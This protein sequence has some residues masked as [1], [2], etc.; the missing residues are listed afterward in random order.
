MATVALKTLA[1]QQADICRVFSNPTRI[2]IVWTLLEREMS[3]SAIAEAVD[4]SLQSTS[5]H[6]RIMKQKQVLTSRRDAQTVY[7][8]ISDMAKVSCQ[9]VLQAAPKRAARSEVLS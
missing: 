9:R 8:R 6:L 1:E 5:Q 7:Y 4:A 3:V 2:L